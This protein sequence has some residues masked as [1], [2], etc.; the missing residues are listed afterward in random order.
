MDL[1]T[2]YCNL[3]ELDRQIGQVLT[4]L[5]EDGLYEQTTVVFYSDHGGPFPRFKRALS[6]A[7]AACSIDHQ[8]GTQR[9]RTIAQSQHALFSGS[10]SICFG[11][12]G[13]DASK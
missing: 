9:R 10:R 4:Q 6:D 8:M 5:K 11:M 7:R 13:I 2:N 3:Q 12:D 1:A